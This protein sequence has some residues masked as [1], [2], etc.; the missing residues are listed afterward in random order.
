MWVWLPPKSACE[1]DMGQQSSVTWREREREA[2]ERS[3]WGAHEEG[4]DLECMAFEE[5]R[6]CDKGGDSKAA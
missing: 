1:G 6:A 4:K 2:K 3:T 5:E